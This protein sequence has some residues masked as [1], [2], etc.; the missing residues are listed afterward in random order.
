MICEEKAEEG[1]LKMHCVQNIGVMIRDCWRAIDHLLVV[2][3]RVCDC[4][5]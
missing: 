2:G 3:Y 1:H 5:V 4:G